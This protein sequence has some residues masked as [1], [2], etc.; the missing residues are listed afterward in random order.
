GEGLMAARLREAMPQR[1]VGQRRRGRLAVS[2]LLLF[3]FSLTIAKDRPAGA[4]RRR[5]A[6][7]V[8]TD[9]AVAVRT[10]QSRAWS[11]LN[12]HPVG[13]LG[14]PAHGDAFQERIRYVAAAPEAVSAP[15]GHIGSVAVRWE[16]LTAPRPAAYGSSR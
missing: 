13:R 3:Q 15:V 12:Q 6:I 11:G 4:R 2:L 10:G 8:E 9:Q 14:P 16:V 5:S 1:P 7:I